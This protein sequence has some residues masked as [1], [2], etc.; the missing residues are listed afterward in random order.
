MTIRIDGKVAELPADLSFE[1]FEE[2]RFFTDADGY[3]L[4]IELPLAGSAANRE[5]FGILELTDLDADIT[6]PMTLE[7]G[8]IH[9]TGMAVLT[10]IGD[11]TVKVQFLSG[12]SQSNFEARMDEKTLRD[13]KADFYHENLPSPA[14]A[15]RSYDR[16]RTMNNYYEWNIEGVALPWRNQPT[17]QLQNDIIS[18][19]PLEWHWAIEETGLS[20]MPYL[21]SVARHAAIV[22][23]YGYDFSDW[24]S[25]DL[26]NLIV[27]NVLPVSLRLQRHYSIAPALPAWSILEFFRNIEPVLGGQFDIDHQTRRIVFHSTAS[28]MDELNPVQLEDVEDE[29][30]VTSTF[31]RDDTEGKYLRSKVYKYASPSMEGWEY[32]DCPWVPAALQEMHL[33]YFGTLKSALSEMAGNATEANMYKAYHS[34]EHNA[35]FCF[36]QHE[37]RDDGYAPI[38]IRSFNLFGPQISDSSESHEELKVLPIM[39]VNNVPELNTGDCYDMI[40]KVIDGTSIPDKYEGDGGSGSYVYE[41]IAVGE[42]KDEGA[43][44]SHLFL[45]YWP[46]WD[47]HITPAPL[48]PSVA[49]FRYAVSDGVP[50][51]SEEPWSMRLN[52]QGGGPYGFLPKIDESV[53]YTFHFH[54]DH[55]PDVRSI[56]Y[57]NGKRYLCGKLSVTIT[58]AGVSRRVKGEFYP[59]VE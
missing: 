27:C 45:A 35:W 39:I 49:G 33:R 46:G 40:S 30:E 52:D 43:V 37:I 57:I 10:G 50:I 32:Y 54:T 21:I 22:A 23:G 7:A 47:S 8:G 44:Y 18:T 51:I 19:S 55:L 41:T 58:A 26:R 53:K 14:E 11:G 3:S 28:L 12:R 38:T 9:R 24:E 31:G 48:M 15:L 1:Y 6:W 5:I 29:Y 34:A 20:W 42:Q 36:Y 16:Q 56:F 4:E 2:N 25:S 17:G 13:I 59:I